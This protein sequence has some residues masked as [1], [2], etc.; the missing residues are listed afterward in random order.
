MPIVHNPASNYSKEMWKW[1]HT[2]RETHPDDESIRGMRPAERQQYPLMLYRATKNQNGQ[3][4]C[5]Q[6]TPSPYLFPDAAAYERACQAA[7]YFTRQCQRV[8]GNE[9]E[10][11]DAKRDGWRDSPKEALAYFE[12]LE[13]DMANAA[14]EAQYAAQRMSGKARAELEQAEEA[15]GQEHA[16]DVPAE[17]KR[18]WTPQR[19]AAHEA[20]K[21]AA[22]EA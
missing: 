1:D 5:M 22:V 10:E 7:E 4:V 6:P 19:R 2:V 16:T 8:V 14:A 17:A 18:G 11:R 20:R 9:S 13:V 15:A 12:S 21:A 3:H